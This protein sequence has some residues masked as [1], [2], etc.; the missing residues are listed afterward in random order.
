VS[1]EVVAKPESQPGCAQESP[2]A[3]TLELL[4]ELGRVDAQHLGEELWL[5]RLLEGSG[6]G[7]DAVGVGT[8][9]AAA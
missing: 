8:L 6:A 4:G 1:D 5:E 2:V 7:Q 9:H 3:Q